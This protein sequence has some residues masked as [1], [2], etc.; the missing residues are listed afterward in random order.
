[1]ESWPEDRERRSVRCLAPI[2][3]AEETQNVS[4]YCYEDGGVVFGKE[5]GFSEHSSCFFP[6]HDLDCDHRHFPYVSELDHFL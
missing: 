6:G 1:M 5:F 4:K 3:H 2:G